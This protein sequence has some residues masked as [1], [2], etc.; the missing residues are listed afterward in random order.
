[1]H[2]TNLL[3]DQ[4]IAWTP[5]PDVIERAQLTRFMRQVG[6]ST[7]DE[8]YEFS[9]RDVEKFTAEVLKFL[10]ITFDPPYTRLLDTSNGIEFPNWFISPPRRG[11]AEDSRQ[12]TRDR[13][14]ETGD[15][16]SE[17]AGPSTRPHAGLNITTMCLDRW[18]TDE[19]KDQPAVIWEGEGLQIQEFSYR[20]LEGDV[21]LCAAGL[22]ELGFGKRDPIGIHLPMMYETVVALLAINRIGAI[23]VPVFSGY[24]VDAISSRLNAV[25]ARALFTC[26]GFPRRGKT[27]N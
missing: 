11:D 19:M 17:T 18:Q 7:W 3:E 20:E 23:A 15:R 6:V 9:I 16:R 8:L 5:T 13:R 27:F 21:R 1:M 10:D 26:D 25:G 22:R 2:D 4:P 12:E 14:Q 24:G